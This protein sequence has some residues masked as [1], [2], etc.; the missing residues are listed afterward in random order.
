M[1]HG[2]LLAPNIS[3]VV[4]VLSFMSIY[5][6]SVIQEWCS[7]CSYTDLHIHMYNVRLYNVAMLGFQMLCAILKQLLILWPT[8]QLKVKQTDGTIEGQT[9]IHSNGL[10]NRLFASEK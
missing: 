6:L 10:T 4:L 7:I 3:L 9:D 8:F 2:E 1:S 5:R